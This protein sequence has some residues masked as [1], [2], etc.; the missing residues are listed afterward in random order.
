MEYRKKHTIIMLY[1][2]DSKSGKITCVSGSPNLQLNSNTLGPL[3]VIISPAYKTPVKENS[4]NNLF[5]KFLM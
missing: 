2:S 1:K 3:S 5:K 4:R